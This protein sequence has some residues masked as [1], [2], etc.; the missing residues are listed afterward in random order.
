MKALLYNISI[1]CN[2]QYI[3]TNCGEH[4]VTVYQGLTVVFCDSVSHHGYWCW[5]TWNHV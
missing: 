4:T 2:P 5:L 3:A 1:S